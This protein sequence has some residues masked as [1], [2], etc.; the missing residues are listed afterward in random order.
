MKKL[1]V[2][3]AAGLT[4]SVGGMA[5][6]ADLGR[7]IMKAPPP[8]PPP[9]YSWTGCYVGA[10]GGYGMYNRTHDLEIGPGFIGAGTVIVGNEDAGG[11]GWL[12]TVQVGCDFQIAQSIVIGAFADYDWRN[13]RGQ[14]TLAGLPVVG[15]LRERNAWAAGGRIGWLV[16]PQLLSYVS[17]GYTQVRTDTTNFALNIPLIGLGGLVLANLPGQTLDGW[18]IGGGVEYAL[19]WFPG[20]FWKTEYRFADYRRNDDLRTIFIGTTAV[21]SIFAERSHHYDQT[22]RTELVWRFNMFGGGYGGPVR[23]A[24]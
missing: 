17:A 16:N 24:Y 7:P 20:L 6:A 9:I 21:P 13:I 12:A 15:E 19:G 8:P 2:A 22:I 3:A 11:R 18:F 23:A 5:G 4:L 10:G 1:L 14:Y